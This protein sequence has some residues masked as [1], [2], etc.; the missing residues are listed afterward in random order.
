MKIILIFPPC[1]IWLWPVN[2]LTFHVISLDILRTSKV[3]FLTSRCAPR[4]MLLQLGIR[5]H[6]VTLLSKLV[7]FALQLF[8]F[9]SEIAANCIIA[10]RTILGKQTGDR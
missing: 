6:Q 10:S 3:F 4:E 7:V 5:P 9:S 1:L 8:S 2:I